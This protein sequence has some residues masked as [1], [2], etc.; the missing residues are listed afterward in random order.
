MGDQPRPDLELPDDSG[1]FNE[2]DIDETG[3]SA[4]TDDQEDVGLISAL[5]AMQDAATTVSEMQ[6]AASSDCTIPVTNDGTIPATSDGTIPATSDGTIP[7]SSARQSNLLLTWPLHNLNEEQERRGIFRFLTPGYINDHSGPQS[8][9]YFYRTNNLQPPYSPPSHKQI[10]KW[11]G[12]SRKQVV[13]VVRACRL[14]AANFMLA[15]PELNRLGGLDANGQPIVIQVDETH[16]GKMKHH[17]GKPRTATW[18]LG[19]IEMPAATDPPQKEPKFFAMTVP[20]RTKAT[21]IPILKYKIKDDSIV[22]TDG[23]ASYFTLGKH[24]FL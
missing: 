7:S 16:C 12:L 6:F 22:W 8:L 1:Y 4:N 21:L 14:V 11:T 2:A 23:W 24:F 13:L 17:R 10:A 9:A 19:G 18:V 15:N 20:N 5:Q 3:Q